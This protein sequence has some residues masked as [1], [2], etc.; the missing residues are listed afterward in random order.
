M[1]R[2]SYL[3]SGCHFTLMG[4]L[5]ARTLPFCRWKRV[6]APRTQA[7]LPVPHSTAQTA[8]GLPGVWHLHWPHGSF[9][10]WKLTSLPRNTCS[11]CF[12][13]Q[14]RLCCSLLFLW[15]LGG[16]DMWLPQ[17]PRPSWDSVGILLSGLPCRQGLPLN[18]VHTAC[19]AMVIHWWQMHLRVR[20]NCF[21]FGVL[22][23]KL[24]R[25][26]DYKTTGIFIINRLK[27][28]S[29]DLISLHLIS[30]P[31]WTTSPIRRSVFQ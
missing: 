24:K 23:S 13:T 8:S 22:F 6:S 11:Q 14:F 26:V 27:Q 19:R 2:D 18:T 20:I 12:S 21:R 15:P 4:H 29:Y 9:P 31:T 10:M 17:L 25:H 7:S 3:G 30:A 5:C 28:S 16:H 1:I